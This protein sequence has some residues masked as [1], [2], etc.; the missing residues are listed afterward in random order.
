MA[1]MVGKW[2]R[3]V[4]M[5]RIVRFYGHARTPLAASGYHDPVTDRFVKATALVRHKRSVPDTCFERASD[6]ILERAPRP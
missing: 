4:M 3:E 2:I 6:T 1:S 5:E